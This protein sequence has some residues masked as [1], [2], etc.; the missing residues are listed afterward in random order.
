LVT[1]ADPK[2]TARDLMRRM[3]G[4]WRLLGVMI[5]V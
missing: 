3:A 2:A 5:P 4:I 1:A